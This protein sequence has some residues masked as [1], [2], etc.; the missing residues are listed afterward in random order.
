MFN[1]CDSWSY[2]L[3][4]FIS[5]TKKKHFLSF[6]IALSH[7]GRNSLSPTFE[8]YTPQEKLKEEYQIYTNAVG[9]TSSLGC[10]LGPN[11]CKGQQT[12][13]YICKNIHRNRNL[14]KFLSFPKKQSTGYVTNIP[15]GT[16]L[17]CTV[18][19]IQICPL[20]GEKS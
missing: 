20:S 19:T 7:Y 11:R 12:C 10:H 6:C 9:L 15:F 17:R 18:G 1:V 3:G 2:F 16:I 14:R 8:L 4:T 13:K 5:K